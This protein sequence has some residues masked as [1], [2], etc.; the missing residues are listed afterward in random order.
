MTMYKKCKVTKVTNKGKEDYI[1]ITISEHCSENDYAIDVDN[2]W[3]VN[4]I[5]HGFILDKVIATNDPDLRDKFPKPSKAFVEIFNK[6][7]ISE[8]LV[9]YQELVM[10]DPPEGHMYGFP[11][12]TTKEIFEANELVTLCVNL[13]YPENVAKMYGDKFGVVVTEF[14]TPVVFKN[15]ISIK[16]YKPKTYTRAE[17]LSLLIDWTEKVLQADKEEIQKDPYDD[18]WWENEFE[19]WCKTKDLYE[20]KR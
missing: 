12:I 6:K 4:S 19:N 1:Y 17:V 18:S 10:I 9:K 13:G 11:K 2:L 5:Y 16:K 7:N 8:I 15:T 3:K 20:G 14:E